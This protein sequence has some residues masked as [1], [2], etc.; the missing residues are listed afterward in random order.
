M[1]LAKRIGLEIKEHIEGSDGNV[2]LGGGYL[3]IYLADDLI[4]IASIPSPNLLAERPLDSVVENQDDFLDGFGNG[5]SIAIF[6]SI[7]GIQW[8]LERYP[9]D[10]NILMRLHY[11]VKLNEN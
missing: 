4:H 7:T 5:Y 11:R 9:N 3:Y 2:A 10:D 1:G 6:S 8:Y